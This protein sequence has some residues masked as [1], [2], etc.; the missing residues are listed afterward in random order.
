M[1]QPPLPPAEAAPRAASATP[2]AEAP[3]RDL[4]ADLASY[5]P[6]MQP[7]TYIRRQ[8]KVIRMVGQVIE[9]YNPGC[10]AGALCTVYNPLTGKRRQGEVV[11]F[12]G[13][14]ILLMTLEQMP[15]IGPHCLVIPSARQPTVAVGNALLGRV[16]DGLGRPLDSLGEAS[17]PL[18]TPL[19]C[20]TGE[21]DAAQAHYRALRCWRS[22]DER[23]V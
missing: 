3:G 8:G 7:E 14:R 4:M 17:S 12:E 11:G 15:D 6:A 23:A 16:V 22:G 18:R 19:V 10:S 2:F 20:G 13:E 21:P 9:A 1:A 5:V